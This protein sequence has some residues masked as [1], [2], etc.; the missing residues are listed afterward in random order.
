MERVTRIELASHA[1]E[2]RVLPLNYT[3][4]RARPVSKLPIPKSTCNRYDR[5]MNLP[6]IFVVNTLVLLAVRSLEQRVAAETWGLFSLSWRPSILLV[7]IMLVGYTI[8][9]RWQK[10]EKGDFSVRVFALICTILYSSVILL[11][12]V[13]KISNVL[14]AASG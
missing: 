2:A 7:V 1:W 8:A 5:F 11:T 6:I 9:L 10:Q 12:V 13:Y 3:R 14:Y 4:L